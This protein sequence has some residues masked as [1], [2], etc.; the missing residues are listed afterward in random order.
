[1]NTPNLKQQQGF[2]MIEVLVTTLVVSFGL[3]GFAGLL[4]ESIQDNRV[5]YMRSQ[6]TVLAYSAIECMR[7]NRS[8][9]VAGSYAIA[10]GSNIGGTSLAA[11]DVQAWK[12]DL[13]QFLPEGDGSINVDSDGNATVIVQ[14]DDDGDGVVT[15][16]TTQTS[17]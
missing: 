11:L 3:L 7:A 5:A 12:N 9:A 13:T 2:T 6:A 4:T 14:W 17:I 16:F 8:A 10:L 15:S 1:M